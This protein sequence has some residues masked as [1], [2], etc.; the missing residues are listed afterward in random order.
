[1]RKV[2]VGIGLLIF[3]FGLLTFVTP[4]VVPMLGYTMKT[5]V[6]WYGKVML[7]TLSGVVFTVISVYLDNI[8]GFFKSKVKPQ[9]PTDLTVQV[10]VNPNVDVAKIGL[11]PYRQKDF[12][13][14]D[15]L[16]RRFSHINDVEG[17]GLCKKMIERV[18]LL[19]H[20]KEGQT[21]VEKDSG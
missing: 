14:I 2:L 16:T 15:Y 10:D 20:V 13:C 12:E 19:H 8:L 7:I 11:S 3:A 21:D 1:M 17:V 5:T 18:F 4:F 6:A 9:S